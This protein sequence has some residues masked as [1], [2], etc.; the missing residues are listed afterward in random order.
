MPDREMTSPRQRVSTEVVSATELSVSLV[1]EM[2]A[3]FEQGYEGTDWSRFQKDLQ[4]KND[5]V[6]MRDEAGHVVGFTTLAVFD[7]QTADGLVRVV[8]SGDTIVS[9]QHRGTNAL[10]F[11]WIAHLARIRAEFPE[12]PLYWLLI[13]KGFRTYRYLSTFARSYV[14]GPRPTAALPLIAL[15][16][17]LAHRLFGA[18]YDAER[19]ILSWTPPRERLNEALAVLPEAGRASSVVKEFD[20][21]NPNWSRGDELVCLCALDFD[22]MKP[23]A[24]RLYHRAQT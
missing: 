6:L 4:R 21:L 12:R 13:S 10:N 23:F 18:N 17:R 19:G 7:E 2:F 5:V 3:L 1:A 16:D 22:N 20:Q 8:F 24:Q 9:A 15:R 14:S 11:A